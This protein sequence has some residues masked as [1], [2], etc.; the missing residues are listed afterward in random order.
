MVFYPTLEVLYNNY[1]NLNKN[2][3][4][5]Y[6]T[7]KGIFVE[8]CYESAI[9]PINIQK[10]N[11]DC[12]KLSILFENETSSLVKSNIRNIHNKTRKQG[13]TGQTYIPSSVSSKSYFIK[14][15]KNATKK[16]KRLIFAP[17]K[18]KK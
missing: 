8:H 14:P 18:N 9:T 13:V 10:L 15:K 3:H 1:K 16:A 2:Q 6:S 5:I 7:I 17:N 4:L 11:S 12:K